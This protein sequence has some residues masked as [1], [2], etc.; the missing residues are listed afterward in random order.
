LLIDFEAQVGNVEGGPFT[1]LRGGLLLRELVLGVCLGSVALVGAVWS[2]FVI[3]KA[4]EVCLLIMTVVFV[5]TG[6]A[7]VV[8]TSIVAAE[9]S[10][11]SSVVVVAT[12]AT[13]TVVVVAA[14]TAITTF[15]E[16]TIVLA[17]VL[18]ATIVVSSVIVATIIL[19]TVLVA[20]VVEAA[21]ITSLVEPA[22]AISTFAISSKVAGSHVLLVAIIVALV[23]GESILL[24]TAKLLDHFRSTNLGDLV[25]GWYFDLFH[26]DTSHVFNSVEVFSVLTIVECDA[27]STFASSGSSTRSMDVG[28]GVFWRLKLDDKLNIW[29]IN[30]SRSNICGNQ[31]LESVIF[32]SL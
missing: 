4:I 31:N 23:V 30:S 13:T 15:V 21:V 8:T 20:P 24:D 9:V 5:P 11:F 28:L 7:S 19:S 25:L 17:T 14:T 32:K 2:L 3:L 29:N 12:T 18:V 22:A 6:G 16:G 10:L 27:G 1:V 26:L